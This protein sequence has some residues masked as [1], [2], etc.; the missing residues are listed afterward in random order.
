MMNFKTPVVISL[1][2]L[3][4][5]VYEAKR[6]SFAS[7]DTKTTLP[8]QTSVY[9]Y[10]PFSEPRFTGMIYTDMYSGNT[11][12]GGQE[13]V[14]IDLVLRWR[15]QYYGGTRTA[16]WDTSKN[17]GSEKK[18]DPMLVAIGPRFPEV[19]SRFLKQALMNMTR[20]FPVRGPEEF[21]AREVEFEGE[22]FSGEW[23]YTNNWKGVSLFGIEDPFTSYIGEERI[24]YNGVEVYWHAYHGGLVRDK[25][26]PIVVQSA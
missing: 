4:E 10:R 21:S 11:I 24:L 14:T 1:P 23:I 3:K 6:Q 20:E 7:T 13:S 5:F 26:F 16:F 15:N 18:F 22:R 12:E 19:V 9:S 25:Y 8:D 2:L 17:S